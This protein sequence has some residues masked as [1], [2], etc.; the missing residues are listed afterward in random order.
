LVSKFDEVVIEI[1][2]EKKTFGKLNEHAKTVTD[3]EQ[4]KIEQLKQISEKQKLFFE[5]KSNT[6]KAR[7]KAEIRDLKLDIVI[8]QLKQNKLFSNSK[9]LQRRICTFCK[10]YKNQP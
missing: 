7:L 8:K 10:R 6:Q 9:P 3:K 1:D 5:S 2:W 4:E